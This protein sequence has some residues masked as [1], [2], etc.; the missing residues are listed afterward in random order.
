[1]TAHY[2][3]AF[4]LLFP[5]NRINEA[6]HEME[7][8]LSLDPLSP[9]VNANYAAVLMAAHRY[10]E[11]IAQ[12]QK[13]QQRDPS[14]P[15]AHFKMSFLYATMGRFAEANSEMLKSTPTPGT[16]SAD[17]K[18]YN[19]LSVAALSRLGEW[20][21]DVSLSFALKG[22]RDGAF[23]HLNQAFSE[24]SSEINSVIRFPA[25]DSLRSDPRYADLM[26][27]LNLPQ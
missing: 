7:I 10:P 4:L 25:L 9:I 19:E 27:R 5:E 16:W 21:A 20:H 2:F 18:G 22:D 8:A 14:F 12:F 13:T 6:L 11:A 17:A 3:Y 24:Q 1:M 26:R 15:P 23:E